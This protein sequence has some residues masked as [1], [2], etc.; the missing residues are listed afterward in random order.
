[1]VC[2]ELGFPAAV[3]APRKA[4]F[5]QGSGRIW[6]DNVECV[7]YESSITKCQHGGW[8]NDNCGHNEDASVICSRKLSMTMR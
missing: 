7:G 6:L 1:M 5:G 8:G 4:W 3:E 2:R